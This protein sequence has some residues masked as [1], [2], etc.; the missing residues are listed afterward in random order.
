V[1]TVSVVGLEG[2]PE[3]TT[4]DDLA[5]TIMRNCELNDG[6]ILV[7]TSKIVSKVE[8]RLVT[9]PNRFEAISEESVRVV[10]Q[11]GETII[12]QTR[13]GFVMAAAGVDA[14]NLP[15]GQVALLPLDPDASARNLRNQLV[16]VSGKQIAVVITDTF[17]RPWR[18][19]LIDQAIGCSGLAVT[20]DY[21]G[22]KDGFGNELRATITAIAD[23]IASASEL[24]RSKL[25]QIP[26]AIIRGLDRYVTAEE[27]PGVA[28]LIRKPSDDWFR[29]GHREVITTRR[30]VRDFSELPI[31]D[32]IIREAIAA[33]IT[34]PAPHHS[35]PWRFAVVQSSRAKKQLLDAMSSAWVAD[36]R[37]DGFTHEAIEKRVARGSFLYSAPV[38]I[39]PCLIKTAK[40]KY[41]DSLRNQSEEAMFTLSG[42]AA[43]E[44]LLL[45]LNAEGIGSAWVS[46]ALFCAPVVQEVLKLEQDWEPLGTIAIGYAASTPKPRT[47]KNVDEFFIKL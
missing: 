33:A 12:S 28:S 14:S 17:G 27:G 29:L 44:N 39:I 8:G 47:V 15:P 10:A 45:F 24:V 23:E 34:A 20:D 31:D 35:A 32:L 43:I 3:F 9:A 7:V 6:D 38:L 26:V 37:R 41:S 16:S 11:R 13:H 1:N 2:L 18:D 36:L 5:L 42:G 19:G 46:A 25:S 22:Q 4:G 40:H 30:T 21:R